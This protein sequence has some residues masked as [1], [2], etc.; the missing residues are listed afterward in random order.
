MLSD[1][2]AAAD[3][4]PES[5]AAK[6]ATKM[7]ENATR[8]FSAKEEAMALM[9]GVQ[10]PAEVLKLLQSDAAVQ[11][12]LKTVVVGAPHSDGGNHAVFLLSFAASPACMWLEIDACHA[13]GLI[14]DMI[15]GVTLPVISGQ[16]GWGT[17]QISDLA[18]QR[19]GKQPSIYFEV[20][21]R[22]RIDVQDIDLVFSDFKFAVR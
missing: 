1:I 21:E 8:L 15:C 14:E 16:R 9:N 5:T 10:S 4:A 2:D 22:V 13:S 6:I 3:H 12:R 11:A 17:Y 7:K 19:I 20:G 18:I